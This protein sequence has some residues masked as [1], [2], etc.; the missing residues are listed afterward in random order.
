MNEESRM[1][2]RHDIIPEL[3]KITPSWESLSE[4]QLL[5]QYW[6]QRSYNVSIKHDNFIANT[7]RVFKKKSSITFYVCKKSQDCR[8]QMAIALIKS[9]T[10]KYDSLPDIH[11]SDEDFLLNMSHQITDN[12]ASEAM[13]L[14]QKLKLPL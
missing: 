10:G 7:P 9:C 6:E 3:V 11:S 14:L 13:E 12:E 8:I 2:S 1:A 5:I 4:Q